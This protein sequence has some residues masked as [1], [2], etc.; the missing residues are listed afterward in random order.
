MCSSS[1]SERYPTRENFPLL[2][3]FH[4]TRGPEMDAD[5][6]CSP[7]ENGLGAQVGQTAPVLKLDGA[8]W[9]IVFAANPHRPKRSAREDKESGVQRWML[10]FQRINHIYIPNSSCLSARQRKM[11]QPR[12]T[13]H[14]TLLHHL[15][16]DCF[17]FEFYFK[18]LLLGRKSFQL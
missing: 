15:N 12:A 4:S 11:E 17:S 3:S 18:V 5:H 6:T 2:L 13:V 7:Q 1:I 10:Y 16:L 14:G 8:R 9:I